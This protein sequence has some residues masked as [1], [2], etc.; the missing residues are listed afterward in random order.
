[1]REV[2]CVLSESEEDV[3]GLASRIL[4]PPDRRVLTDFGSSPGERQRVEQ[5]LT[6]VVTE[7]MLLLAPAQ[8]EVT[9]KPARQPIE[10]NPAC[11]DP[12]PLQ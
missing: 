8:Y 1:M 5:R 10:L 3:Q 6:R 2:L 9:E 12:T 11:T 4:R 7:R